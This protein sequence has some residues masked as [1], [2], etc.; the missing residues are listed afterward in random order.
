MRLRLT[1]HRS[2]IRN[3][4]K[5]APLVDHWIAEKHNLDEIKWFILE[6]IKISAR[7]GD[8]NK[9]RKQ[10]EQFYMSKFKSYYHGLNSREEWDR[11]IR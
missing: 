10:R 1:E 2:A 5:N 11:M 6:K 4:K 3:Q 8:L 7:G 9:K